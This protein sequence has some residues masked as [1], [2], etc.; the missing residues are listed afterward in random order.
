MV[1]FAMTLCAAFWSLNAAAQYAGPAVNVPLAKPKQGVL[2]GGVA[3]A[4]IATMFIV[5][6]GGAYMLFR[7]LLGNPG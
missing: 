2:T 3:A 7:W 6:L 5:L 4:V 1:R